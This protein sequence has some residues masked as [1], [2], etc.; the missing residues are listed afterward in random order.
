MEAQVNALEWFDA[1]AGAVRDALQQVSALRG[2]PGYETA[3]QNYERA[4]EE[5]ENVTR[6]IGDML[7]EQGT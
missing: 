7:D 5:M 3:R 2:K 6:Q 1:A 4:V